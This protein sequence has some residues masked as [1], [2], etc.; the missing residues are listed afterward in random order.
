[1]KQERIVVLLGAGH[2][3]LYVAARAH[4]LCARGARVVLVDPDEFWYSGLATGMLGG[5]YSAE[6]DRLDPEALITAHGGEFLRDWGQRVD[7]ARRVVHLASGRELAYDYLSINVGSRVNV[8]LVP[9]MA[10]DPDVWPVKPISNLWRLRQTL[11]ISYAGGDSPRLAVVGG[12][13]TGSEI[14]ANLHALAR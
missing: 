9:G 2:A 13:P 11:E 6:D 12:G 1:M 8:D 5:M 14:A 10:D 7:A 4:E 3:H